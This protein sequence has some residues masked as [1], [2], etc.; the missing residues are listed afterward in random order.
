MF[1]FAVSYALV[2]ARRLIGDLSSLPQR[3]VESETCVEY[4]CCCLD[5]CG[6]TF[7]DWNSGILR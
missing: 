7:R 5:V 3:V 6:V 1:D 4:T 2:I